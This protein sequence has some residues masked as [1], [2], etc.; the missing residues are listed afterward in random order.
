MHSSLPDDTPLTNVRCQLKLEAA[1]Q[2]PA[3][4]VRSAESPERGPRRT[5]WGADDFKVRWGRAVVGVQ[6]PHAAR[7]VTNLCDVRAVQA[8]ET[9]QASM[10]HIL[11]R[12]HSDDSIA[13]AGPPQLQRPSGRTVSNAAGPRELVPPFVALDD[14]DS[15]DSSDSDECVGRVR[16]VRVRV[17]SRP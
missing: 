11:D 5:S 8:S 12:M 10:R 15:A 4:A 3:I 16:P 17:L 9:F 14:V 7:Q 2:A 1:E 13:L 6:V